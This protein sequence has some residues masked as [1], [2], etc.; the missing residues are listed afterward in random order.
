VDDLLLSESGHQKEFIDQTLILVARID[1]SVQ[2]LLLINLWLL[3]GVLGPVVRRD[4]Q[5]RALDAMQFEK[6]HHVR[7]VVPLRT[8][9]LRFR[10]RK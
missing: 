3:F 2:F 10:I 6:A 9:F 8:G 5:L 1:K 7:K 4:P